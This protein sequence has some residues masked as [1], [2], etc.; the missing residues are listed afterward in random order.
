MGAKSMCTLVRTPDTSILIDPGA[1]IMQPGFPLPPDKKW[2]LLQ[3][4]QEAIN[5]AAG[6]AEH[7]IISHYHYDHF[8]PYSPIYYGK[9]LWIKDPNRW[10]NLSQW[11]RSRQFLRNLAGRELETTSPRQK[12]FPD[13]LDE[14]EL[15]KNKDFG[16]YQQR[17]EELLRK[18]RRRFRKLA[19]HWSTHPWVEPPQLSDT[20]I[21]YA[22]GSGF[23][24]GNTRVRFTAPLFH[25]IEYASTG[26]VI[27]TVI[28]HG[29]TKLIHTSDLGGPV[30]EDYARWIIREKPHILIL[31]GPATY[32]LG[33]IL[34]KTNLRRCID[35]AVWIIRE[36]APH[37]MI[38][39]H[40]LT[41]DARYRERTCE[42][43]NISK[44][45]MTAA[46][47][48]GSRPVVLEGMDDRS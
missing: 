20:A 23:V 1:A 13:P 36:C 3:Q 6:Q 44:G 37:V 34:N 21:H 17:R 5:R 2:Q 11:E 46:E 28:E 27:S 35:N 33:Y 39:D 19:A 38:Y 41:R 29:G 42:V 30:I 18:W 40:H 9:T 12:E 32:L 4:A 16:P 14:L 26:W 7:I 45:V 43:W 24:S 10:I 25:G 15:A 31:D 8:D 22:D 47:Y 48:L